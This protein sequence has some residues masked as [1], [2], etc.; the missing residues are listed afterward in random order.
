MRFAK[1]SWPFV[2]PPLLLGVLLAVF[3][4]FVAAGVLA[5][6]A[7]AILL[8]FRDPSRH[9]DGPPQ[10]LV[11]P[12]DGK[13][14]VVDTVEAPEVGPGRFHQVITFL[15]VFD[16]HVQRTPTAGEVMRSQLTPGPKIAAYKH[17]AARNERHLAVLRR[18]N[19][20][21]V[22]IRQVVG[23]VARRIVCYLKP[24]QRVQRGEAL[25]LIKFGSRVDL[26]VPESYE[27]LVSPGQRMRNGETVMARAPQPPAGG[28]T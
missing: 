13:V 10:D 4:Y 8:F 20:D 12:A 15:N 21:L 18:E 2:L 24:G 28:A 11:A 17:D 23:L 9:Y 19:G 7:V 5:V 3:G 1:E 16:V 27:I 22:G 6:L 14:L 26:L 25:G